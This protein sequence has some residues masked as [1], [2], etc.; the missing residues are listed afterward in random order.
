MQ[1]IEERGQ[2]I[3]N[4]RLK[5]LLEAE[6]L[7]DAVAIHLDTGD[8]VVNRNWSKAIRELWKKHPEGEIY[9]QFIGPPTAAEIALANKLRSE[10]K[11]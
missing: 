1:T 7:G 6:H 9:A 5:A 10:E 3:Y 4:E 2:T 8:Y 11:S